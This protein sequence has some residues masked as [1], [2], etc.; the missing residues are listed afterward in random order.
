MKMGMDMADEKLKGQVVPRLRE[1][2]EYHLMT[3][4]VL[5]VPS[6]TSFHK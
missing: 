6:I 5:P 2:N 3:D 1:R 4:L